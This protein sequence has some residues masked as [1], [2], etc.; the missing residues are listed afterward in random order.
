LWFVSKTPDDRHSSNGITLRSVRCREG[1]VWPTLHFG[2]DLLN[3]RSWRAA[4]AF[5]DDDS[6]AKRTRGLARV[7]NYPEPTPEEA[8]GRRRCWLLPRAARRA[9]SLIV[10]AVAVTVVSDGAAEAG[11]GETPPSILVRPTGGYVV[12]FRKST[13]G[14]GRGDIPDAPARALRAAD[15]SVVLFAASQKNRAL[16]GANLL[17]ARPDCTVVFAGKWAADPA[18]YDDRLWL[19]ST[20]TNDGTNIIAL[21]HSEYQV[22]HHPGQCPSAR[23][24]A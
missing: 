23:D 20:W 14:C 7:R 13:D 10:W 21:V 2:H 6:C 12:V 4:V 17:S 22:N 1:P 15:G 18:A 24:L 9:L 11:S 5:E 8:A 19:A 16:R 3:V